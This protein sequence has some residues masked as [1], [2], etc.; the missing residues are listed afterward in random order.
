MTTRSWTFVSFLLLYSA[1][2][3]NYGIRS[4]LGVYY[5]ITMSKALIKNVSTEVR[6]R[7]LQKKKKQA[8]DFDFHHETCLFLKLQSKN[9]N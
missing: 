6:F 7:G 1:K 3:W 2:L 9:F 5:F 8:T 4:P